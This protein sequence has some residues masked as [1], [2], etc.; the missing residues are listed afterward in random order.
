MIKSVIQ[1][2]PTYLMGV[3]RIPSGI[4]DEIRSL[5]AKFWWGSSD[6]K[7]KVHWQSWDSM[8]TPKCLGGLGFRDMGVFNEALLGRQA[9]RLISQPNC[10]LSRVMCNKYYPN[11]EFLNS[12]L[13]LTGSFSWRGLWGAKSLVKDGLIWR[14]GNG[15]KIRIWDVTWVV[16]ELGSHI[17]SPRRDNMEYVCELIDSEKMEWKHELAVGDF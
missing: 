9:W 6:L 5:T 11:G 1:A 3:Y 16:D 13:G 14:V 8:C 15:R 12:S 7:R 4:I 2:I 17:L 10:L